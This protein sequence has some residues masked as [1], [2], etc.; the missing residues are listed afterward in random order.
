MNS[1]VTMVSV[2]LTSGDVTSLLTALV[3]KMRNHV[4]SV[5]LVSSTSFL[6]RALSEL[7]SFVSVPT[8]NINIFK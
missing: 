8:Y 7:E 1:G 5:K 6:S 4:V 2:F 3:A